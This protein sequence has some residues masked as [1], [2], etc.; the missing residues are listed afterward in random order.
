VGAT[1]IGAVV[2]LLFVGLGTGVGGAYA[3]PPP[4]SSIDEYVET[5]PTSTGGTTKQPGGHAD[6]TLTE[7]IRSRAGSD[8]SGLSSLVSSGPAAARKHIRPRTK[9]PNRKPLRPKIVA[10]ARLSAPS[11]AG[12][13]GALPHALG[14]RGLVLLLAFGA[15]TGA[16]LL[17]GRRGRSRR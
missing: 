6:S 15:A 7:Q 14:G 1:P 12:M 5:F 3:S 13:F 2:V 17:A 10:P 8:A 11:A 4:I 16:A 9:G